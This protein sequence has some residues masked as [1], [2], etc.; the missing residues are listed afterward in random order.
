[1]LRLS[2]LEHAQMIEQIVDM[3][4]EERPETTS[5]IGRQRKD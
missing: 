4:R 5:G 2:S 1:M 3:R